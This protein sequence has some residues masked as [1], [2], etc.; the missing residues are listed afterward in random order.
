MRV[1][2]V[3]TWGCACGIATYSEEL[4]AALQAAGLCQPLILASAD[5]CL[6]PVGV[7]VPTQLAWARSDPQLGE[8]L[9]AITDTPPGIDVVH[10]QHEDGLFPDPRAFFRTLAMLRGRG[11]VK[12]VVTMHTVREYGGW[13]F[14]GFLDA[15][16][17][18]ADAVV[19]HTPEALAAIACSTGNHAKLT[20][21]PH[22][23]DTTV[24]EGDRTR[25][26]ELLGIPETFRG[27]SV[28]G[29]AFGFFGPNKNLIATVRAV[30]AVIARRLCSKIVFVLSGD[31][32]EQHQI[33]MSNVA[34]ATYATG[35][36]DRFILRKSFTPV[37]DIPDVMAAVDFG[38][39]NTT[40]HVLSASGA[41]N[42][43]LRH[44][45]PLAV[46]NRPI[47][48]DAIRAGAIP[49]NIDEGR[50]EEPSGSMINAVAALA[51]SAAVR[52]AV[53]AEELRHI[54][55]VAW[56]RVAQLHHDLYQEL[57][58]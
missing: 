57:L 18:L 6:R 40:S 47:Y 31:N 45:V 17:D 2:Y 42:V 4:V 23:C 13:T 21:I 35:Y 32:A 28:V 26:F 52:S 11:K 5:S 12:T 9:I 37:A 1:A 7:E 49:F 10:F 58:K 24:R 39:L 29:L 33:Y 15:L 19:V 36:F 48:T 43:F 16:V 56:S 41:A 46:A 22:G 25:G 8:H 51:R 38:V 20:L 50:V 44:G 27:K 14:S 30:G 55:D 34:G 3:T 53:R 54:Q